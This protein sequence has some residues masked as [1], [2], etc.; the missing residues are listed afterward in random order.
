M[1]TPRT[2]RK[3]PFLAFLF[4]QPDE[5]ALARD[6]DVE[7]TVGRQDDAVDAFLEERPAGDVVGQLD[8]GSA[9]GRAAG[10]QFSDRLLDLRLAAPGRRRQD[11]TTRTG[12][13]D[14]GD[15]VGGVE[16][17]GQH[18][19]RGLDERQLVG[20]VHRAGDVEQKHEVSR[21]R[22]F[23][24][25]AASLQADERE[26]MARIPR[27]RRHLGRDRERRAIR[28]ILVGEAEV[29]DQLFDAHGVCRRQRALIEEAANV[30]V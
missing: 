19:H 1:P 28:R 15:A 7:I 30:R 3:M 10:L 8:A 22:A 29:V 12:V 27:A 21:R 6:A 4:D 25:H 9:V 18:A 11:E 14:D 2:E 17:V 13:D 5:L 24:S 26:A 20:L 23:G 16:R